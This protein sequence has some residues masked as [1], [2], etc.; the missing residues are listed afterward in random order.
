M[1]II[2]TLASVTI[3][4][5]GPSRIFRQTEDA[6]RVS[7]SKQ[8]RGALLQYLIDNGDVPLA[9]SFPASA[10]TA[11]YICKPGITNISGC[12]NLDQL[13]PIYFASLP[14]D[15]VEPCA[16]YTGYKVYKDGGVVGVIAAN[17]GK[18]TVDV[19]P[20]D[21]LCNTISGAPEI[22]LIENSI[23]IA[24]GST[25]SFGS[26]PQGSAV[27]KTFTVQNAGTSPL[28]L[29]PS[30]PD[31]TGNFA[32]SAFS[33]TTIAAAGTATFT[34]TMTAGSVG[35]PSGTLS[36]TTNDA[37][38]GSYTV[39]VSGTVVAIGAPEIAVS[40][41]SANIAD[42]GSLSFGPTPQN[43]PVVKTL[44]ISNT[45]TQPLTL[46]PATANSTSASF[47]I[48]AFGSTTIV[49]GG[50]TT[51]T[52]T[53]TA[54]SIGSPNST[55]SFTTNDS[56]ESNYDFTVSGTVAVSA[57]DIALFDGANS[58]GTPITDAQGTAISFGTTPV[59]TAVSKTFTIQNT[60][61]ATLTVSLSI[62]NPNTDFTITTQP[63]A[64]T[65][66][67][68][69]ERTFIMQMAAVSAGAKTG[70]VT[71]TSDDP[72]TESSFTFPVAGTVTFAP[73]N[74]AGLQLWL[75]A[76][77]GLY[78]D[79]ACTVVA[80]ATNNPVGCW[81]DQSGIG[82]DA[83]Q[84]TTT[85]RP[86]LKL[87]ALNSNS[88]LK[89]DNTDDGL[90]TTTIIGNPYTVFVVYNTNGISALRRAVQGVDNNWLV[91][92]YSGLHKFYNSAFINGSS[93]MSG[94]FVYASVSGTSAGASFYLG[95]ALIGSNTNIT[96]PSKIALGAVGIYNEPLNG[97][98][99]EVIA[100]NS[101]LSTAN[102]QAVELYL[103]TKYGL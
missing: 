72:D 74:I 17:T 76:D 75:K 53:M 19:G 43:T 21:A 84:L 6:K 46:S 23:S 16:N 68:N 47:T 88:T 37:D 34:V 26:T 57:P 62:P 73:N 30:T 63:A 103:S 65:I 36:F 70:T 78:Q 67:A 12:I 50:T 77:T 97:E 20:P 54:T 48:G 66:A 41:S 7:A 25:D 93:V 71:I 27:V 64:A 22:N 85:K 24:S 98:I 40:E 90:K 100:Y 15:P 33:A 9:G 86:L 51:F 61:N 49:A 5:I 31:I 29:S 39:N 102:R 56:D 28:I 92:P 80:T 60:G 38:E 11:K 79:S 96:S 94:Q 44:T 10:A 14:V 89:L 69:T 95:G 42:G 52:I 101:A 13:I 58:S 3:A 99:A 35:T 81:K 82:N 1:G 59:G 87:S 32:V 2:G 91:G 8:I 55:I 45:G 18:T 83:T 4:F